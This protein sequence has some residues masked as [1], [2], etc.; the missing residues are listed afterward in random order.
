MPSKSAATQNNLTSKSK[1]SS[2][3]NSPVA[4]TT[5]TRGTTK[6]KSVQSGT[7]STVSLTKNSINTTKTND[8]KKP[9]ASPTTNKPNLT[10]GVDLKDNALNPEVLYDDDKPT[11]SMP[12]LNS[13]DSSDDETI[14]SATNRN[15]SPSQK[16]PSPGMDTFASNYY[17]CYGKD[18]FQMLH[19]QIFSTTNQWTQDHPHD[20]FT[21][22]WIHCT[23]DLGLHADT[24]FSTALQIFKLKSLEDY[25]HFITTQETKDPHIC[26]PIWGEFS[27][28]LSVP[29]Y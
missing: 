21:H 15:E 9:S 29:W 28:G 14:S 25:Y 26:F 13:T 23:D 24:D 1:R 18:G 19:E 7:I 17:T 12:I 10:A 2:S 27:T 11:D 16:D 3:S 5:V 4:W 20:P 22:Y 8:D 6:K